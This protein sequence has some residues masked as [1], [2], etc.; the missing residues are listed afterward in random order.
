MTI[1]FDST[2]PE[3][4]TVSEF[5]NTQKISRGIFYRLRRRAAQE[6]AAVLHPESRASK[7]S[8]RKYGPVVI[9]ELVR[10][11]QQ[12]KKDGWDYG[13]KTI[14][15]EATISPARSRGRAMVATPETVQVLLC[16]VRQI[17]RDGS[18]AVGRFRVSNEQEPLHHRLPAH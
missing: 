3:D 11:R 18:V 14:H 12:L 2:Q 1:N 9:N 17:N 15:Y 4:L 13:P 8:A 6:S 16:S 7:S 10:I 5:C